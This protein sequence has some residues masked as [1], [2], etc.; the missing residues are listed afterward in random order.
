MMM[1]HLEIIWEVFQCLFATSV[2][3]TF[4]CIA[5]NKIK[6]SHQSERRDD[7]YNK[8]G[9]SFI[10]VGCS[11]A[12]HSISVISFE[13]NRHHSVYIRWAQM[14]MN[15]FICGFYHSQLVQE[16]QFT[17]TTEHYSRL[18]KIPIHAVMLIFCVFNK[19]ECV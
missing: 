5:V 15:I 8:F 12:G 3:Y 19:F 7:C 9:A 10:R 11:L 2:I 14:A 18:Y 17:S 13:W 4:L 6:S 1:S 16:Y